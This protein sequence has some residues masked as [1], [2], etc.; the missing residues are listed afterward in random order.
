MR[1]ARAVARPFTWAASTVVGWLE[2]FCRGEG[3]APVFWLTG[4]ALLFGLYVW[5]LA[6]AP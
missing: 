1:A 5:A 4:F 3:S 2:A 6:V